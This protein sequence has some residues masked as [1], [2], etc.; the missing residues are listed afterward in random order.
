VK[1]VHNFRSK[2]K[3]KKQWLR[4]PTQS[5]IDDLNNVRCQMGLQEVGSGAWNGLT[6]LRTETGDG[7]L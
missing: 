2:E 4:D 3:A 7:H 1:N 6:W 5:N